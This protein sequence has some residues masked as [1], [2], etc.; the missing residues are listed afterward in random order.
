LFEVKKKYIYI[1]SV[2]TEN[3]FQSPQYPRTTLSAYIWKVGVLN[4]I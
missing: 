2:H 4:T 1:F 3:L